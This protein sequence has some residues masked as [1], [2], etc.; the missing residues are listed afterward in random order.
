MFTRLLSGTVYVLVQVLTMACNCM[1][2]VERQGKGEREHM[3]ANKHHIR[4][5][6]S[7]L[8]YTHVSLSGM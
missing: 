7:I 1:I 6:Y 4:I 5:V 2:E 3:L 8:I